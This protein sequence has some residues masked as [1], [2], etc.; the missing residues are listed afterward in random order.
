MP[1]EFPLPKST[2]NAHFIKERLP[3]FLGYSGFPDDNKPE[4]TFHDFGDHMIGLC[5][6]SGPWFLRQKWGPYAGYVICFTGWSTSGLGHDIDV[7]RENEDEIGYTFLRCS[8]NPTTPSIDEDSPAAM[9]R[10]FFSNVEPYQLD[11][12]SNYLPRQ[13]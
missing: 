1:E 11:L 10:R 2:F 5:G 13:D 9:R 4:K 3:R 12:P 8:D 7:L 6:A